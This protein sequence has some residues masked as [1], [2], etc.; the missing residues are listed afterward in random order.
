MTLYTS[1]FLETIQIPICWVY[2][3]GYRC[4][5][6]KFNVPLRRSVKYTIRQMEYLVVFCLTEVWIAPM[7]IFWSYTAQR[8][9]SP[10][11]LIVD[12]SGSITLRARLT[13]WDL[14]ESTWRRE[15]SIEFIKSDFMPFIEET[16]KPNET[17]FLTKLLMAVALS[18]K[19][20]QFN[21]THEK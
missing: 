3:G 20:G 10:T 2:T 18:Q 5:F 13:N 15:Y 8:L 11:N 14:L 17:K 9:G 4:L 7:Q 21:K 12:K 6:D 19:I 1:T 16:L